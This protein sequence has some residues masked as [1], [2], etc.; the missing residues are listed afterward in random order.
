[1][2]ITGDLRS[3]EELLIAIGNRQ[4]RA[5]FSELFNRFSSRIYA[6][7]MKLTRN[8]PLAE[9][10]VQ[11]A[12][13]TVWQKAPLY[14]LD[15]GSAQTWVFTLV[16]NRCFDMLRKLKRQPDG[17]SADDVYAEVEMELSVDPEAQQGFEIQI[18]K[19]EQFYQLLPAAQKEVIQCVF[20]QDLTHQEAA[21][22]LR[23]PLGTLKSRLRLALGKLRDYIG[24]EP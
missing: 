16:R 18:A 2:D 4:D 24:V 15:K 5:A 14:D 8:R 3:D 9:D 21:E 20:L 17:I 12:L 7:G 13:L 6:M 1:M 10:L 11:E 22:K 19:I 23:I